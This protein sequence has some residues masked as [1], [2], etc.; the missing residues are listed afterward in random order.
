MNSWSPLKEMIEDRVVS[1][2]KALGA[3]WQR[4]NVELGGVNNG[5]F[6]KLM[7]SLLDSAMLYGAEIWE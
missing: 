6:R 5:T 2:K 3:W 7:S 1:G 4:C